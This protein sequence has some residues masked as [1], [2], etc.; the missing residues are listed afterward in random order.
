MHNYHELLETTMDSGVYQFNTRTGKRCR[1]QVGNQLSFDLRTGFPALTT[2]K[3][4]FKNIVGE[5]LGFFR[6]VTS[7]AD[8][9][10][11]GCHFW[12]ANANETAAW[13]ANPYREG[14]D[15]LFT[16]RNIICSVQA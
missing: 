3:L 11:L 13:L 10:A 7:A 8:F 1:A 14:V 12:D 6:G 4:P 9:R 15:D 2:R 16:D 5:L